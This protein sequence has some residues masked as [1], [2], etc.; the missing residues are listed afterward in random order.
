MP[1]NIE[2]S[3]LSSVPYAVIAPQDSGP[4]PLCVV[5]MGGGG[6]R[7]SLVDCQP[8]FDTWWAGGCSRTRWFS[9]RR[10]RA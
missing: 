8:L 2:L 5:L 10:A 6:S 3:E 9:R 7:Q 4:L 1:S